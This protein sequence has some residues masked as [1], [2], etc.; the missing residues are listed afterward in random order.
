MASHGDDANVHDRRLDDTHGHEHRGGEPDREREGD[1]CSEPSLRSA[2]TGC[3][4][5]WAE[6]SPRSMASHGDGAD[7]HDR[8]LGDAHGHEHRDGGPDRERESDEESDMCS[9]PSP[10]RAVTVCSQPCQWA[11]PSPRMASSRT[12]DD[13]E[14]HSADRGHL[15]GELMVGR[16]HAHLNHGMDHVKGHQRDHV[17]EHQRDHVNGP[18]LRDPAKWPR[19]DGRSDDEQREVADDDD[20][21]ANMYQDE[22][23]AIV[24]EPVDVDIGESVYVNVESIPVNVESVNVNMESANGDSEYWDVPTMI[25]A[26]VDAAVGGPADAGASDAETH[27]LKLQESLIR[28]KELPVRSFGHTMQ[29]EPPADGPPV[30]HDDERPAV[31]VDGETQTDETDAAPERPTVGADDETQTDAVSGGRVIAAFTQPAI[32]TPICE[33]LPNGVTVAS[34]SEI[35]GLDGRTTAVVSDSDAMAELD[36]ELNESLAPESS[37]LHSTHLGARELETE[38]AIGIPPAL[39]C[40]ELVRLA[41]MQDDTT[42]LAALEAAYDD[43]GADLFESFRMCKRMSD[44][45]QISDSYRKFVDDLDY[46]TDGRVGADERHRI[47]IVID[48]FE[49]RTAEH[50]AHPLRQ[51]ELQSIEPTNGTLENAVMGKIDL[52]DL[53]ICY[54]DESD[55]EKMSPFN[56]CRFD[57]DQQNG[58][59]NSASVLP[60][61]PTAEDVHCAIR[62]QLTAGSTDAYEPSSIHVNAH[63]S[64]SKDNFKRN[65]NGDDNSSDND[66]DVDDVDDNADPSGTGNSTSM[67]AE[68]ARRMQAPS[69]ETLYGAIKQERVRYNGK[70]WKCHELGHKAV[71]CDEFSISICGSCGE[72]G[73]DST[74]CYNKVYIPA[75]SMYLRR[76]KAGDS[77]LEGESAQPCVFTQHANH[78]SESPGKRRRRNNRG[79]DVRSQWRDTVTGQKGKGVFRGAGRQLKTT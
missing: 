21:Y 48:E 15:D 62:L 47:N 32:D 9:E 75:G 55:E 27:M 76:I 23:G 73:H 53:G 67:E 65:R 52:R 2:V 56:D 8:R 69:V 42:G 61:I 50:Q 16:E 58:V 70:C 57:A 6:P 22:R 41:G 24:G 28:G 11:E 30:E 33:Q 51:D 10:R 45:G 40:T 38:N 54:M 18:Q 5:T 3:S 37:E 34:P 20:H 1:V 29:M 66:S 44:D 59:G 71:D 63:E 74:D 46:D 60:P 7:V 14:S 17:K 31:R 36:L 35:S 43:I 78:N 77:D 49:K 26:V 39:T 79:K 25:E 4:Q 13:Y 12:R 72:H 64:S 68:P 19:R